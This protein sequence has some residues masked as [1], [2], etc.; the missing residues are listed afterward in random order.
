MS[1]QEI[2]TIGRK[3]CKYFTDD[4]RKTRAKWDSGGIRYRTNMFPGTYFRKVYFMPSSSPVKQKID[5]ISLSHNCGQ[6][7]NIIPFCVNNFLSFLITWKHSVVMF[8]RAMCSLS[9]FFYLLFGE[10]VENEFDWGAKSGNIL[11]ATG[12]KWDCGAVRHTI[13]KCLQGHSLPRDMFPK[14]TSAVLKKTLSVFKKATFG[15]K[16][17]LDPTYIGLVLS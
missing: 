17:R 6:R 1:A 8:I 15:R 4:V 13:K 16:K 14:E 2:N 11:Q 12:A 3:D 7:D 5:L 9:N 10:R